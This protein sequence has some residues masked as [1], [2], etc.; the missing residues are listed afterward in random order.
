MVHL[1]LNVSKDGWETTLSIE[2]CVRKSKKKT[3]RWF[4]ANNSI[5][6]SLWWFRQTLAYKSTLRSKKKSNLA[7]RKKIHRKN[8]SSSF[9]YTMIAYHFIIASHTEKTSHL[10]YTIH[11]IFS[12]FLALFLVIFLYFSILKTI[13][14]NVWSQLLSSCMCVFVLLVVIFPSNFMDVSFPFYGGA[15]YTLHVKQLIAVELFFYYFML[16]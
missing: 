6:S 14:R 4:K 1:K 16:F 8:N 11:H 3:C 10:T 15:W 5:L 2:K 9:I 13:Y 7:K 12:S